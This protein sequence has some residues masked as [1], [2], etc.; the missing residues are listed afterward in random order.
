MLVNGRR[1]L[2]IFV[3]F[4]LPVCFF[5]VEAMSTESYQFPDMLLPVRRNFSYAAVNTR[6][7]ALIILFGV[8]NIN[9]V[10]VAEL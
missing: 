6:Q 3:R 4:F 2:V 8:M 5:Q 1:N 7:C 9:T 10:F